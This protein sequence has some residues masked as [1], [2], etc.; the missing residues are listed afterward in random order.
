MYLDIPP[1]KKQTYIY[2]LKMNTS[3]APIPVYID[4][5]EMQVYVHEKIYTMLIALFVIVP[6]LNYSNAIN[7]RIGK[8]QCNYTME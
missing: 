5:H 8:I 6:N 1:P 3:I 4:T 2:L 7:R